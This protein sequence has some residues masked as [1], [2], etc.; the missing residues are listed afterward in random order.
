MV[1]GRGSLILYVVIYSLFNLWAV[2]AVGISIQLTET[3]FPYPIDL[4]FI[5]ASYTR[6][7]PTLR[8]DFTADKC[9]ELLKVA[10]KSK[11]ECYFQSRLSLPFLASWSP[12]LPR[13]SSCGSWQDDERRDVQTKR[14]QLPFWVIQMSSQYLRCANSLTPCRRGRYTRPTNTSGIELPCDDFGLIVR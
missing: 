8:C 14:V 5:L 1:K 3:T 12:F 4:P 10:N 11:G 13:C 6:P 9:H 7:F 2:M